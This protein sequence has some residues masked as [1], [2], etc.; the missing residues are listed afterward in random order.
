VET[1]LHPSDSIDNTLPEEDIG[2]CLAV[3][4]KD[5]ATMCLLT[6]SLR[7]IERGDRVVMRPNG[8]PSTGA[9]R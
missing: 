9:S 6:R 5:K 1:F 8:A 7:D 4:V 2:V 3:D